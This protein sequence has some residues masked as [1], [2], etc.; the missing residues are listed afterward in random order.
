ML[1]FVERLSLIW[2][3]I[4]DLFNR[5]L[6]PSH[7]CHFSNVLHVLLQTHLQTLGEG[8]G[9]LGLH[10]DAQLLREGLPMSAGGRDDGYII[11]K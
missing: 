3:C 9:G 10:D 8:Q 1:S 5:E 11:R 7:L 2:S 4:S 6:F